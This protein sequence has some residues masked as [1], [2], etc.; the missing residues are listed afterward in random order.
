MLASLS[1]EVI[2]IIKKSLDRYFESLSKLSTQEGLSELTKTDLKNEC[3]LLV[4]VQSQVEIKTQSPPPYLSLRDNPVY[5]RVICS[6]LKCYREDLDKSKSNISSLYKA[7]IP[8]T[9]THNELQLVNE[10]LQMIIDSPVRT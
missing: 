9:L 5:N 8:L 7:D 10:A 2:E 1:R 6:A 4:E 3:K